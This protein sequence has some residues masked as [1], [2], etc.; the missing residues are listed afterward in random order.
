MPITMEW[1]NEDKTLVRHTYGRSW[2][3][4]EYRDIL[5]QT[6]EWISAQ[7][8]PVDILIVVESGRLDIPP[9]MMTQLHYVRKMMADNQRYVVVVTA[10]TL[11]IRLLKVAW[12]L[13]PATSRDTFIV[14]TLEEAY[15]RL[16]ELRQEK[17]VMHES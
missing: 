3:I 12:S 15:E 9:G 7:P 1:D 14:D 10:D 6:H 2:T 11:A 5:Q 8:H 13:L 17:E 4:T 16:H